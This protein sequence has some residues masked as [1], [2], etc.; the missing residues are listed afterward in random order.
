MVL[1]KPSRSRN[2]IYVI[3]GLLCVLSYLVVYVYSFYKF[4]KIS[5]GII[6]TLMAT[7]IYLITAYGNS[8]FLIPR[9]F[10]HHK[11]Q[12]VSYSIIFLL[13]ITGVRMW[14]ENLILYQWLNYH[15]FFYFNHEH[16]SF[17]SVTILFAFL[18]GALIRISLNH[19]KLLQQEEKAKRQQ[20]AAELSLLKSQV[21]PHFLF[22]ALNNIYYLSYAK[23]EQAPASI[24]RLSD[25]MRYFVEEAPKEL[26][27]V[28]AELDFIQDYIEV[29]RIRLP[30]QL[31]IQWHVDIPSP[32]NMLIP[33][34]L[35][36]PLVE[37]V[38][39]HGVDKTRENEI[40][41]RFA[42]EPGTLTVVVKNR[43]H[44]HRVDN[45]A[46]TGLR[47]LRK[48][49]LLIYDD[50]FLLTTEVSAGYFISKMQIPVI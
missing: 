5:L 28:K 16:F 26:V 20:V 49:L 40:E 36:I 46:G 43:C 6:Y 14:L 24:A 25:T 27:S 10:H 44:N 12:Y 3:Q 13:A 38:F 50:R 4:Q 18:F 30:Y 48:R 45:K 2:G 22:N 21:Q 23:S 47:N 9:F 39:K 37:N 8:H 41:I 17:S 11:G 34:M 42:A 31:R 15:W 1:D 19:V 33:P 32:E 29:E 35:F 7:T